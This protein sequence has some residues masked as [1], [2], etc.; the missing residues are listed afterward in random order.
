MRP[1]VVQALSDRRAQIRARWETLLRIEHTVT[2]LANPDL[3]VL[4]MDQTLDEIF[5]ALRRT[6]PPAVTPLP[7]HIGADNPFR[8]YYQGAEQVLLEALVLEQVATPGLDAAERDTGLAEL[9][10]VVQAIASRDIAAFEGVSRHRD[11]AATAQLGAG[12]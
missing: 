5:A 9:K 3:L 10:T 4:L 11:T 2:P 7:A 1:S 12:I 6:R 8:I